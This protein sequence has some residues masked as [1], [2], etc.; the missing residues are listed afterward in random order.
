[1]RKDGKTVYTNISISCL[2]DE[3]KFVSLF[4]VSL[5]DITDRKQAEKQ[6]KEQMDD[7][8]K[9]S[10]LTINREEKMIKLKEEINFLMKQLGKDAKY[11]IV[12]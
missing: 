1:M 6:M 8:Q 4:L 5:L 11:K 10:R 9:F 2:R 7:L 3:K 12:E